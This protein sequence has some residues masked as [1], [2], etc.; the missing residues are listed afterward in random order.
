VFSKDEKA[1]QEAQKEYA[2]A[3]DKYG[4]DNIVDGW[5]QSKKR[6]MLDAFISGFYAGRNYM[7]DSLEKAFW[8]TFHK[9]G[10]IWFDYLSSEEKCIQSTQNE[11]DKL[12]YNQKNIKN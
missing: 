5:G 3:I 2:E 8:E 12:M 1:C 10:K 7:R 6:Y 9:S 4:L 11:W